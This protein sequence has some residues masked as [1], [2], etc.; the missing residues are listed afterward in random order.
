M[1][2][3]LT[4]LVVAAFA[5]V[6]PVVAAPVAWAE[7]A[8]AEPTEAEHSQHDV[9]LS[10]D[11]L[12]EGWKLVPSAEAAPDE[13]ALKD[14]IV[15]TSKAK[16]EQVH[17][18][19]ASATSP[20]GKKAVFALVDFDAALPEAVAALKAAADGKGW[21]VV[22]MGHSTRWL[23]VSAPAEVRAKAVEV[24]VAFAARML[25]VRATSALG[26]GNGR[27][28]V[29]L[30]HA[31]VAMDARHAVGN[32]VLGVATSAE[33]MELRAREADDAAAV[34][35]K[36]IGYMKAAVAKD[37]TGTLTAGERASCLGELGL[38][39]LFTKKADAE[40]RDVLKEAVAGTF[41]EPRAA[42]IARYNLACA[43]GRLKEL[44]AAFA[45][46]TTS[47][48]A[49]AKAG[50]GAGIARIWRADEDLVSLKPDPRWAELEKKFPAPAGS[51]DN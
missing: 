47:L 8:A 41:D 5:L 1:S 32:F 49:D 23:V 29:A 21:A 24:Q 7:D 34:L 26:A 11:G 30:A 6:V 15:A 2:P 20:D 14:A 40:A 38:S 43:H 35:A 45:A 37:A 33:A 22:T 13:A 9:R 46:L 44:D 42:V 19:G 39:L 51:G 31:I 17:V 48:E 27:R 36:A 3:R 12:P 4:A 10:A 16:P 28:A 25:G 50:D 18:L